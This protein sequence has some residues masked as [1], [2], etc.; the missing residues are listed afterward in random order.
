VIYAPDDFLR[1]SKLIEE[2]G[3]ELLQEPCKG[4]MIK[5]KIP[6]EDGKHV[7]SRRWTTHCDFNARMKIPYDSTLHVRVYD[8]HSNKLVDH[9]GEKPSDTM[10][11]VCAVDDCV[12]LWPRYQDVV[13]DRSYQL[14]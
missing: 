9:K 5:Y 2:E 10:A 14:P 12:G 7:W 13:S 8:E 1:L 11:T 6:T 3:G 4:D